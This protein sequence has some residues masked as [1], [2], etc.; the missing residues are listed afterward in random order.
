MYK[1]NL[2]SVMN[3]RLSKLWI[4]AMIQRIL[5]L[6]PRTRHTQNGGD[7][8]PLPHRLA[9]IYLMV[10][11]I[12]WLVS[13]FHAWLGIPA[14]VLIILA[15]WPAL[16][17]FS[18]L[19]SPRPMTLAILIVAAGW[20]ISTAAGGLL[21][22]DNYD[23]I[24]HRS[25]LLNLSHYPW[26]TFVPDPLAAYLPEEFSSPH[27]LR[28]YLGWYIV[29]GFVAH[30]LGPATLNWAVPLWTWMGLAL[31]LLLFVRERRGWGIILAVVIF[32]FFGGLD[33][34]RVIFLESVAGST[35]HIDW[36]VEAQYSTNTRSLSWTPQHFLPAGL[37]TLL[38]LQLR[39][40][41]RFLGVSAVLL[42]AA[43]FW[44]SLVAIGLLPLV[45]A[46]LWKNGFHPFLKWSNLVLAAPLA[47]LIAIYLTSGSLEHNQGW[48]WEKY[49]WSVLARWMPT[50]YLSEFLL[51][52]FLLWALRPSLLR[53]P[54]IIASVTTLILLPLYHFGNF[55]DLTLQ[56]SVPAI[57]VLCYYCSETVCDQSP[58]VFRGAAG[59]WKRLA[60]AGTA[61]T[62]AVGSLAA[63]PE[64][65]RA[66]SRA[67][68][69]RYEQANN[70]ITLPVPLDLMDQYIVLNI[71]NELR[72]LLDSDEFLL[73]DEKAGP[74]MQYY[75]DIF[76]EDGP[77][78]P[79]FSQPFSTDTLATLAAARRIARTEQEPVFVAAADYDETWVK[80][81][82]P[83]ESEAQYIRTFDY[84]RSIIF[85]ADHTSSGYLFPFDLP[86]ASIVDRY[87][88]EESAQ[89]IGTS[90][91]GR[92]ITSH[93]LVRPRPPFE[94][95]FP[96]PAR[97]ADQ[98]FVYGFDMSEDVRAGAVLTVRW[99]WR[100]LATDEREFGFTNQV[101]GE[102]DLLR[103]QYDARG[104]APG[105]WPAGTSGITTFEIDIDPE[106]PT[107]AYWLRVAVYDRGSQEFSNL[108]V[109]DAQGNHAGNQ[110]ILGPFKVHGRPPA[111]SSD[112]RV[113]SPPIPQNV[114]Q[115]RFSDQIDLQGYSFAHDRLVPGGSLELTLF[116]SPRGRPSHDYTVFV[117]LLDSGGQLRGQADSP[118]KSGKYPTSVWDAGEVIVDSHTLP[119]A[120]DLPAGVYTAVIGL[121][122]PETGQ[123][124][125]IV[126][127]FGNITA[128]HVMI[129][130]L[131]V[132]GE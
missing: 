2:V 5:S 42:A 79:G 120:P 130:G 52:A 57:L 127:E 119:L 122:A 99:Y 102:D 48:V 74:S 114:L 82:F 22:T 58:E 104:F 92:P 77:K 33:F 66:A 90:P 111:Q 98:V 47:A 1:E 108:D 73:K 64:F 93:R 69:F 6:A 86:H 49:D 35:E 124:V 85:P 44:S 121:Y 105:Y 20:V 113:S 80:M 36:K 126:D 50:F 62:L 71:P 29:P 11:L 83:N 7:E 123:R 25:I 24:K 117:H 75:A 27:L 116:W 28:Y 54:F 61:L 125:Q 84:K 112:A 63:I 23:W 4:P 43:P 59:R 12:I 41:P 68:V 131:S 96:V 109:F 72:L 101:F 65:Q 10:P 100:L 56:G 37:Y 107:G 70:A 8:L 40:Q 115:T 103:G 21:D 18:R 17:G 60:L 118:P 95:R 129:S 67:G 13:W 78:L 31:I 46:L 94:P 91:S 87:F 19:S 89:I 16:S 9:V 26:P 39:R 38:L 53:N 81:F 34:L 110:L 32:I 132:A 76:H 55:N 45:A 88:D 3:H 97:F 14:A 15:F 128:D 51:L 106:T 30:L